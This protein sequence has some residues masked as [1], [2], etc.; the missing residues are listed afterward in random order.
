MTAKALGS[1][2]IKQSFANRVGEPAGVLIASRQLLEW[3]AMVKCYQHGMAMVVSFTKYSC[4]V[5]MAAERVDMGREYRWLE[6][7]GKGGDFFSGLDVEYDQSGVVAAG[8]AFG[9]V[10]AD[11]VGAPPGWRSIDAEAGN[12]GMKFAC[13]RL[14]FDVALLQPGVRDPLIKRARRQRFEVSSRILLVERIERV[15]ML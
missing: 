3:R 13:K 4:V 10:G 5:V 6:L 1:G 15:R 2:I 7:P 12:G 14:G 9:G 11:H 8:I